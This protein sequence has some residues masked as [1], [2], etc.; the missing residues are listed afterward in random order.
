MQQ[1]NVHVF[2]KNAKIYNVSILDIVQGEEFTLVTD[3]PEGTTW[4]F[5]NDEVLEMKV[6]QKDAKV[7]AMELGK[8]TILLMLP[9]RQV[10]KEISIE[11]IEKVEDPASTLNA[12]ADE[13]EI[14]YQEALNE[15]R[16]RGAGL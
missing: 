2:L 7:T 12:K 1:P 11:V 8:S 15:M 5:D 3:A 16:R 13:P 9:S 4:F 14:K 6:S 10:I